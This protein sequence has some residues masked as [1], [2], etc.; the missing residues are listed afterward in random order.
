[1]LK[2]YKR[3]GFTVLSV[4]EE[5][6]ATYPVEHLG[7]ASAVLAE[8]AA[9]RHEICKRLVEA[10]RAMLIVGQDALNRADGAQILAA[11][12]SI[13]EKTDMV[14]EG[15]NGFNVL[16][17]AASRV[18]GLDLGFVPGEGGLDVAGIQ[19]AA[20]A[21]DVEVVYLL[22]ADELDMSAFGEAFV[23]YQ[24]HHGDAGAH[25]ADVILP[26]A[27]YTEK[28]GTWVNTEGRAQRG[29]RA[30]FPPGDAR[31]DWAI[32]R[33]LSAHLGDVLPYD[34]INAIR[35]RMMEIAPNLAELDAVPAAAW[36][37]F[38]SVGDLDGQDFAL[39]SVDY[40]QTNPICR[41]SA[42][43]ASCTSLVSGAGGK[44]TGTDG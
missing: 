31:E 5:F 6:S 2:R 38:G 15:W 37:D 42:T 29:Q 43:M 22:G 34:D 9:G 19:A 32:I 8:I 13:T 28:S 44:A 12:K 23:I 39:R 41:T 36:G 16:H 33:A 26:G 24:G 4:G 14:V 25:R 21:G 20:G 11:A 7:S 30:V 18:A 40:Y 35:A 10:G 17:N 1:L 27:A 3:G